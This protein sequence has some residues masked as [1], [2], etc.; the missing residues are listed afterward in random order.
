[1]Y[2]HRCVR[3]DE[4]APKCALKQAFESVCMR[5]YVCAQQAGQDGG[6]GTFRAG[7]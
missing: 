3:V 2:V 4:Y 6:D 7:I 1:M 5:A